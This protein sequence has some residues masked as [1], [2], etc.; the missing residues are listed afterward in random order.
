[1]KGRLAVFS[2]DLP[3]CA[4]WVRPGELELNGRE[5]IEEVMAD[6]HFS[7]FLRLSFPGVVFVLVVLLSLGSA[8]PVRARLEALKAA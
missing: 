6:V 4:A 5:G 3:L 2:I 7:G 8:F 1:L